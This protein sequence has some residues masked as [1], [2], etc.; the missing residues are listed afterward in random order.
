MA[1]EEESRSAAGYSDGSAE[2]SDGPEIQVQDPLLADEM[3][4]DRPLGV[5]AGL[6]ALGLL[7]VLF[8]SFFL[9]QIQST[10]TLLIVSLLLAAAI[11]GPVDYLHRRWR[12]GRGLA[13]LLVYLA[14]LLGLA[15]V[16]TAIVPP[17][18]RE[19]TSF[20]RDFPARI[21]DL[22]AD[23]TASSS[24]VLHWA[25]T[26]LFNLVDGEQLTGLLANLPSLILGALSGVGGGIVAVFTVFLITFYW[27]SEKPVTKRA[28][29]GLFPAQQ[30][31]RALRVWGQVEG[32]LGDWIRGQL[33]LMLIIGACA[34]VAY[35]LMQL[36][37]WLV[38]GLI[39]GLTEALPNIGPV[40]GA[41]PAVLVALTV[42]WQW[43][44]VVIV[45]VTVLQ[46]LENAILVPR[47]MKGAVGLSP[48]VVILAIIAGSEFRGVVG[49]L[50][51]VPIAA[52]ASV[53]IGD[54]A[55]ERRMSEAA[56]R[57]TGEQATEQ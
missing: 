28:V 17:I 45:F 8:I 37:F 50:L 55:R 12:L 31:L 30:R 15:I 44:V 52:A 3:R 36:P 48:L 16:I 42:G 22:R 13:I 18:A 29:V 57:R 26:E 56:N 21:D 35:G 27:I 25:G 40:L 1:V 54:I 2:M 7:T 32:K 34:T 53:I 20:A 39:A 10:I 11:S 38:L 47:I 49:A 9:V 23:L 24:P 5:R 43:A 51:A 33:L 46:L 4:G 6:T 41:V 14:I 19:G